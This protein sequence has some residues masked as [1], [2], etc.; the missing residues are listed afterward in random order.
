MRANRVLVA[1][2]RIVALS[3]L[4][5]CAATD[6]AQARSKS[7]S[8]AHKQIDSLDP[9][10]GEHWLSQFNFE[11]DRYMSADYLALVCFFMPVIL[12][13]PLN[14]LALKMLSMG[15]L[16]QGIGLEILIKLF[17]TL[18]V[19]RIFSLTKSQLLYYRPLKWIY[20]TTSTM[21]IWARTQV[22]KLYFYQKARELKSKLT[23][24]IHQW[25]FFRKST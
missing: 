11:V 23:L 20:E 1:I 25:S 4:G 2:V 8:T 15:L 10:P 5:F 12:I 21:L 24:R 22:D 3:L 17:A 18:V 13:A 9:H 14:L 6:T 16:L 7:R 19:S